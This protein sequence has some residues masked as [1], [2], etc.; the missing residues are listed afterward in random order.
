MH[1]PD[2]TNISSSDIQMQTTPFV[3]LMEDYFI[4]IC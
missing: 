2:F 3:H 4:D 1:C